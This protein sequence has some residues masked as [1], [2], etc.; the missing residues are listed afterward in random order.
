MNKR[1]LEQI[2]GGSLIAIFFIHFTL[3]LFNYKL[4]EGHK[5]GTG[6]SS[7]SGMYASEV[8]LSSTLMIL[9]WVCAIA[10]VAIQIIGNNQFKKEYKGVWGGSYLMTILNIILLLLN[11]M[12]SCQYH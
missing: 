11:L 6:I 10:A 1:R 7:Y 12:S 5:V 9:Q 8:S 3:F 2:L 4:L